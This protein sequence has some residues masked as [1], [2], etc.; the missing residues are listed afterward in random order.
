MRW[1]IIIATVVALSG[2]AEARLPGARLPCADPGVVRH[3]GAWYVIGTGGLIRR[4]P[5]LR[6]WREVGRLMQGGWPAW[7]GSSRALWAPELHAVGGRFVCYFALPDRDGYHCIG[8]ATAASPAGPWRQLA[9]PIA[10]GRLVVDQGRRRPVGLIDPTF[11]RD[12]RTGR[13]YL[14]WKENSNALRPRQRTRIVLRE[15]DA[16]GLRLKGSAHA[17]IDNDR[18][19]EDAVVEAPTMVERGGWYYL[20]Y[21]GANYGNSTY[22][23]GVARARS[24]FGPFTKQPRPILRSG[25]RF[26]GPGHQDVRRGPQGEW[27]IFYHSWDRVGRKERVLLYDAVRW[28]SGWPRVHDGRPSEHGG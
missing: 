4:S 3:G 23:V 27:L 19:W 12:P 8:A 9:R 18:G 22:A 24:P 25:R 17:L 5:D 16:S 6:A 28:V 15:V 11:F 20:L 7:A 13:Q 14:L 2:V 26:Y 1:T 21:S 10:K